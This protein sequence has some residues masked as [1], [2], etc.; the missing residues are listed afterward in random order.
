[1]SRW[2]DETIV[3]I[4]TYQR[5]DKQV[6]LERIPKSSG[7]DNGRVVL[8]ATKAEAKKLERTHN[9]PVLVQ[10]DTIT[11]IAQ[12]RAWI[13]EQC[14]YERMI[15]LD[16]DLRFCYRHNFGSP[17]LLTVDPHHEGANR[18]WTNFERALEHFAHAGL[19]A[20]MG[21]QDKKFRWGI[22]T[23]MMYVLGYQT[24]IIQKC[25]LG[26]IGTREDMDYTLQLFQMGYRNLI[27]YRLVVDQTFA[28]NGGMTE[29]RTIERSDKDAV[30]L[31]KRYPG[32]VEVIQKNYKESVPRKEVR[33]SW[34]KSFNK[35]AA[36]KHEN[37]M[38]AKLL[39]KWGIDTTRNKK[40]LL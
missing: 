17:S 20:R 34:R 22:N 13:I 12:K 3:Y 6:T 14:R 1:M 38:M 32:L 15:M 40:E 27:N 16:D 30:R 19:G 36:S 39:H 18:A 33:V 25:R 11:N 26:S 31:A 24:R 8:V 7:V 37:A 35:E 29:E 5:I 9:V 2:K 4:P 23:R 21:S 10:P 28:K